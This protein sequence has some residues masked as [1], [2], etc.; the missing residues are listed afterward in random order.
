M[1]NRERLRV[2]KK[3]G[4]KRRGR[5]VLLRKVLDYLKSDTFMYAPLLSPLPSDAF[6]AFLS[7]P[8]KGF[9]LIHHF[10]Y[11]LVSITMPFSFIV[12]FDVSVVEFTKPV[13]ENQWFGLYLK[14]DVY[15]YHPLLHLPHSPQEPSQ[16]CGIIRKNDSTRR[17]T[18]KVN[19]PTDHLGNA[20][21]SS[22]SH[23][24]Q[25]DLSDQ[26]TWG[27]TETVKHAVYQSCRSTS[28]PIYYFSC[29][30]SLLVLV[31]V[32]S[33]VARNETQF[34]GGHDMTYHRFI[35]LMMEDETC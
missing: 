13:Q 34:I 29:F 1:E 31:F 25:T 22:E 19:Q 3:K 20:N 17:L 5:K 2:Q 9:T 30:N 4:I 33:I 28:A 8:A 11:F 27:H 21:Q 6:N 23:L 32:L 16:D 7:S 35:G 12:L 15:M 18:M 24:P 14:S 10:S 26:H